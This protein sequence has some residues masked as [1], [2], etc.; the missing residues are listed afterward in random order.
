MNTVNVNLGE[1]SYAICIGSGLLSRIGSMLDEIVNA[2]SYFFVLDENIELT[3]GKKAMDSCSVET[4]ACVLQAIEKNK[5]AQSLGDIWSAMLTDECDR[6]VPVVTVGGGIVGDVGGFAAATFMRG[7][8]YVQVPTTLLAMVDAS[9]GGKTGINLPVQRRD[10]EDILGK[11]LAGAFWQP[12]LVVV[13]VDV[14]QTLDDR[15]L[16]CG[17]AECIK[18]AML[19]NK[20]LLSWI[21]KNVELILARDNE[22]LIELVTR[23]VK[24]K[25]EVVE[26]DERE[27]GCRALLNLGHTFAHTIEPLPEQG[28]YHG[29]AVSIGICAAMSY[30]EAIGTFDADRADQI[31]NLFGTVGL[32]TRLPL[33]IAIEEL[34]SSMKTDKKTVDSTLRLVL[35]TA[36][37]AEIVSEVDSSMLSLAW[38][39]VGA[40]I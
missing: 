20:E 38:A 9:I 11:N 26:K 19:G 10:D 30:A 12:K 3:Y 8:P 31:R 32:P 36:D 28:L 1:R 25:V 35:P 14:L 27:A 39:S 2:T 23:C 16:V 34:V 18:H 17:L 5:T 33:P 40:T 24:I 15:Q 7:V 13:D 6:G 29:E 37:G 21:E 22:T 4:F